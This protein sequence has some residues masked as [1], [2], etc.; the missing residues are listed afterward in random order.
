MNINIEELE[1]CKIK[2]DY[3]IEDADKISTKKSEV[4]TLF[5]D[6]QVP[7]CRA[8]KA[9][10]DAIRL[11]YAKDIQEE[12]K[13]ALANDA[14]MDVIFEKKIHPLG[15]PTFH[16]VSLDGNKFACSFTLHIQPEFELK[17]Y[18]GFDVPK[19][20]QQIKEDDLCQRMIQ[21]LRVKN[22]ITEPYGEN[23]FIQKGD[24]VI[25]DY[26]GS[27]DGEPVKELTAEGE[28]VK[29]GGT[30]ISGF[31]DNLLGMTAGEEREFMIQ[32]PMTSQAFQGKF[33]S[34]HV[35]LLTGSKI[36]PAPLDNTLA[37]KVGFKS[38]DDL[39]NY[40]K[41]TASNRI[42]E[43]ET[44]HIFD[45]I[46]K[47]LLANHDFR[48]PSWIIAG[49][50]QINAKQNGENWETISDEKKTRYADYSEKSVKLSMI[51]SKIRDNEPDAA[52]TDE[53]VLHI[54]KLNI[55]QYDKNPDTVLEK[56]YKNGQLPLLA[57][58]IR[59]E[60]TLNYIRKNCNIVE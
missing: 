35:K 25:L 3:D 51:L 36:T 7:G 32:A 38:F 50:A 49:E 8:G 11:Y 56:L 18:K 31:D 26:T 23:D 13:K 53:E 12:L 48:V 52:L 57:G 60:N 5:K 34:F 14:I 9:S 29:V 27:V 46:G 43:I 54:A 24:S 6:K 30:Q 47:R 22:G 58:R 4:L 55:G 20:P 45:Q 10:L 42:K 59:D 37:E 28:I 41:A 19:P 39:M 44:T 33:I 40:A 21:E 17:E 15:M 16:S 1:Y 2:V